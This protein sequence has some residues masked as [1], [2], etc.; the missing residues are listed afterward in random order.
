M[1]RVIIGFFAAPLV[2]SVVSFGLLAVA[3]YPLFL[4]VTLLIGA[5]IFLLCRRLGLLTWWSA[6]LVGC[7]CSIAGTCVDLNSAIRAELYGPQEAIL[8]AP[9]GCGV[10]LLF[11]LFAI[12]RN[13]EFP[14]V[15]RRFPVSMLLLAPLIAL[16]WASQNRLEA[17]DVPA[18]LL[19]AEAPLAGKVASPQAARLMLA[20]GEVVSAELLDGRALPAP[21]TCA[22]LVGRRLSVFSDS[23]HYWLL[24]FDDEVNC[25]DVRRRS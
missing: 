1:R 23:R 20:S 9:M 14:S 10:G 6:V 19:S 15:S 2:V 21:G 3:I 4:L 17:V 13:P 5:P 24:A 11:W 22:D 7:A 16:A 25:K 8:F 12:F 18:R